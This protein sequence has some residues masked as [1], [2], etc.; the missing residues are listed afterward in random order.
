MSRLSLGFRALFRCLGD[1]DFAAGVSSLLATGDESAAAPLPATRSEAVTL[2]AVLQREARLVDFVQEPIDGYADAQVGAAVR[3]VHK[4]CRAVFDRMLA[5]EPA[6][7]E[8]E[9]SQVTV[10][11]GASPNR[12]RMVG[13]VTGEPP[14]SGTLAHHGWRA[15]RCDLPEWRGSDDD[16]LLVAPAEV[17]LR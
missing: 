12:Y 6:L 8:P 7:D 4:G 16:A 10:P 1:R 2:L 14:V 5:F 9:S 13:N 3:E 15:T 11:A 17:E